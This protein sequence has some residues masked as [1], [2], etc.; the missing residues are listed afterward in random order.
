MIL[1]GPSQW[2]STLTPRHAYLRQVDDQVLTLAL[3]DTGEFLVDAETGTTW[4][5]AQRLGR[6]GPLKGENLL[7]VPYLSSFGWA[8]KDFHP[9]TEFYPQ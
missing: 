4:T 5:I 1:S 6:E 9:K 2:C 7:L 3:D 8:W